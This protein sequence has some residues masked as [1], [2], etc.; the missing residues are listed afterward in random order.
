MLWFIIMVC[1]L[2]DV[3]VKLDFVYVFDGEVFVVVVFVGGVGVV[4][5]EQVVDVF[6]YVVDF[7]V[8]EYGQLFFWYVQ[9]YVVYVEVF[10]VGYWLVDEFQ[11]VYVVG[12]VGFIQVEMNVVGCCVFEFVLCLFVGGFGYVDFDLVGYECLYCY[13]DCFWRVLNNVFIKRSGFCVVFGIVGL[14]FLGYY[15]LRMMFVWCWG[16]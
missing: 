2:V 16:C 9:C 3:L 6:F 14:F 1:C 8:V 12:V 13:S 7:Q 5:F 15:K 11:F 10:V 4:E